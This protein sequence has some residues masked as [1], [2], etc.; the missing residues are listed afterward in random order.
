MELTNQNKQSIGQII[1]NEMSIE[2]NDI[3][4]NKLTMVL[5]EHKTLR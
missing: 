1:T 4:H 2:E 3:G 5:I